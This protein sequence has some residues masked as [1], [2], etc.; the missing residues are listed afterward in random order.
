MDNHE[1][2]LQCFT[3]KCNHPF[4]KTCILMPCNNKCGAVMHSCKMEDHL[5]VCLNSIQPCINSIYG[6]PYT[7]KRKHLAKHLSVCPASVI[8]CTMEWNRK[9]L[10]LQNSVK[11]AGFD[12]NTI[13]KNHL[14]TTMALRDQRVLLQA[15]IPPDILDQIILSTESNHKITVPF[16]SPKLRTFDQETQDVIN[17]NISEDTVHEKPNDT[18]PNVLTNGSIHK[19][20]SD[21]IEEFPIQK[22]LLRTK[23][24]LSPK[25]EFKDTGCNTSDIDL[26]A[27][28][29][30]WMNPGV[31]VLGYDS[32]TCM[33]EMLGAYE[34][35]EAISTS[36]N[37]EGLRC[38][39]NDSRLCSFR[40]VATQSRPFFDIHKHCGKIG[41]AVQEMYAPNPDVCFL[42]NTNNPKLYETLVLDQV[43]E[44]LPRYEKKSRSMYTF[45]CNNML[46]RDQYQSHFRNVHCDI[47]S[48]LNGW[49]EQKCPYAQYGCNFSQFRF[50]PD[51]SSNA[52]IYDNSRSCLAVKPQDSELNE[53]TENASNSD[54]LTL[55]DLPWEILD[56][57]ISFLDS[58]SI[59]QLSQTCIA[60]Q[61]FCGSSLKYRGIVS[62]NWDKFKR[63][64]GE[65]TWQTVGETW[66][67]S[68][69]FTTINKWVCNDV[70]TISAHASKCPVAAQL[71]VSCPRD[72]RVKL[73]TT[74][75]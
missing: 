51:S 39:L 63:I 64:D 75:A 14:E 54:A 69:S 12:P 35:R 20:S 58:Y 36:H 38:T 73:P 49:L 60:L 66:L 13:T 28:S 52:L 61:N 71:A 67:F 33:F 15:M 42:S 31:E 23:F 4:G 34:E 74:I 3:Q 57:I 8:I 21:V 59:G 7:L 45:M 6:C 22:P 44:R 5:I 40:H 56:L 17:Q 46:R 50:S 2:C 70:P 72:R 62:Q 18:K 47:C 27:T 16:M 25:K 32:M 68:N 1:H 41:N 24:R 30:A 10:H 26:D 29:M 19:A 65:I 55:L 43:L 48:S 9:P 11:M 53:I 37:S